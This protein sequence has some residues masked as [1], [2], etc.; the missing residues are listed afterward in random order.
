M[1]ILPV[2]EGFLV[3]FGIVTTVAVPGIPLFQLPAVSQSVLKEPVQVVEAISVLEPLIPEI[4]DS[5]SASKLTT[6]ESPPVFS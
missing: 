5:E 3:T 4:D 6:A 2:F 1:E